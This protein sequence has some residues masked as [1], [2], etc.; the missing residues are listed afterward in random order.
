MGCWMFIQEC[1]VLKSCFH[2]VKAVGLHKYADSMVF[3]IL[4]ELTN[5]S[6]LRIFVLFS[7]AWLYIVLVLSIWKIEVFHKL[8]VKK[9]NG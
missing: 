9:E 8:F 3:F 1:L 4:I 2:D 5:S 6:F 7:I